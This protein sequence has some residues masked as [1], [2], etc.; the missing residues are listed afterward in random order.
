MLIV[1]WSAYSGI[2][3]QFN[4]AT[5]KGPRASALDGKFF[6]VLRKQQDGP[7]LVILGFS[8]SMLGWYMTQPSRDTFSGMGV[9][10][11]TTTNNDYVTRMRG[12][13]VLGLDYSH[14][15]ELIAGNLGEYIASQFR[16]SAERVGDDAVDFD[17]AY[18]A[19]SMKAFPSISSFLYET[20]HELPQIAFMLSAVRKPTT[21]GLFH[22]AAIFAG[23]HNIYELKNVRN[24]VVDGTEQFPEN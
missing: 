4:S 14:R 8:Q 12:L 16:E 3:K 1:S 24:K 11:A 13:R 9:W 6:G 18:E 21:S 2:Q 15:K 17:E 23:V 7:L 22:L 5:Y 10:A 20:M 19:H